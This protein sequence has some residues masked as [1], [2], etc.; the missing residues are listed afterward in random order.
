MGPTR[1]AGLEPSWFGTERPERDRQTCR[2]KALLHAVSNAADCWVIVRP[3]A[4]DALSKQLFGARIFCLSC[5]WLVRFHAG[6]G[7]VV[8]RQLL[9]HVFIGQARQGSP[10]VF[11]FPGV[12]SEY[13]PKQSHA[14]IVL[15][16]GG[17]RR[18]CSSARDRAVSGVYESLPVILRRRRESRRR[19]CCFV[20]LWHCPSVAFSYFLG[21]GGRLFALGGRPV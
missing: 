11:V 12:H 14:S 6:P 21:A 2:P 8:Q 4:L 15:R 18:V 5:L 1:E 13:L 9:D 10:N 7:P 16:G 20:G 3:P 19:S 17:L